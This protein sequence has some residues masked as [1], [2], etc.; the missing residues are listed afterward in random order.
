[1]PG[2]L[3]T[4]AEALGTHLMAISCLE[5]GANHDRGLAQRYR[6]WIQQQEAAS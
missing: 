4:V 2:P 1:M 5:G 3:R 6:T